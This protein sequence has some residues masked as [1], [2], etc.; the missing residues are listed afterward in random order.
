MWHFADLR[1]ADPKLFVIF[2]FVIGGF[3]DLKLPKVCKY[4]LFLLTNI[5]YKALI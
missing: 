5:A 4:I 2:G 3:A 1:F